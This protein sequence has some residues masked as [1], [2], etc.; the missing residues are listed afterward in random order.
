MSIK[1]EN[2]VSSEHLAREF[3]HDGEHLWGWYRGSR[4]FGRVITS[5]EVSADLAAAF[6]SC[7]L[8]FRLCEWWHIGPRQHPS[9]TAS[10]AAVTSVLVWAVLAWLDGY[11]NSKSLLRVKETERVLRT[12][13]GVFCATLPAVSALP[14]QLSFSQAAIVFLLL[15]AA[16]VMEKH[17]INRVALYLHTRGYARQN[18]LVYGAGYTG[19]HI[20]SVLHR[21]PHLGMY[22]IAVVDDDPAVVG[23]EMH[24]YDYKRDHAVEIISGPLS[25]D[26]LDALAVD[27][28]IIAI[29]SLPRERF[30]TLAGQVTAAGR[31]LSLVPTSLAPFDVSIDYFDL[32]GMMLANVRPHS[33]PLLG[34]ILKRAMDLA[35]SATLLVVLAPLMLVFAALVKMSSPGPAFFRQERVGREGCRFHI[36]KFRTMYVDA[37][38]YDFSPRHS[39][40]AR[41]TP[42]GRLLRRTSLDE[43]PQ[44]MNVLK[45]EMSLVGPRPEMPFIVEHYDERHQQRLLVKPGI[46]GLWQLSADRAFLIHENIHYDLYYIKNQGFFM[47]VAILLHTLVFAMRGI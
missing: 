29:P 30:L 11:G 20:F 9:F 45:G 26:L 15:T 42:V 31:Q 25:K 40:D 21:S 2:T 14:T 36:Y 6:V 44:L 43:L 12:T 47:D 41:I 37:R 10:V 33:R 32:D 35:I 18:V 16:L 19:R 28:V 7:S 1:L 22:P 24:C 23:T 13:A 27:L 3:S 34:R 5:V 17:L 46:T 38:P 4:F 39:G 8:A